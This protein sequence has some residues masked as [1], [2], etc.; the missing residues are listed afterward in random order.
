MLRLRT[1]SLWLPDGDLPPQHT[2]RALESL[3]ALA[4]LDTLYCYTFFEW[5]DWEGDLVVEDELPAEVEAALAV[6][7]EARPG[8]KV[9]VDRYRALFNTNANMP[10]QCSC[11]DWPDVGGLFE[12]HACD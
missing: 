2:R 8:L 5:E 10:F 3:T 1:L 6:L 11:L 12:F 9:V 4:A 7:R